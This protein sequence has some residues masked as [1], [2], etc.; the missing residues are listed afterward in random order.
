M[1]VR[2]EHL[3]TVT[4][5]ALGARRFEDATPEE[6]R[7]ND[8]SCAICQQDMQTA[9]KLPCGHMFHRMCARQW[10]QRM[11]S[12]GTCPI[13]R[14]SVLAS[15]S[16]TQPAHPAPAPADPNAA[17]AA[18]STVASVAAVPV[19]AVEAPHAADAA[20]PGAPGAAPAGQPLPPRVP[21]DVRRPGE[22]VER[23]TRL[24]RPTADFGAER[25]IF[26]FSSSGIGSWVP[27]PDFTF[28]VTR[29]AIGSGGTRGGT[30]TAALDGSG[31]PRPPLP[32]PSFS[33][34]MDPVALDGM[35]QTVLAVLPQLSPQA[36]RADLAVTGS[37]EATIERGL[38]GLIAIAELP[39]SP[40]PHN[41]SVAAGAGG[42][43]VAP[44]LA[45][46]E[47]DASIEAELAAIDPK[48][49]NQRFALFQAR[50]RSM[51]RKA[52]RDYLRKTGGQ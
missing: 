48:D 41:R 32:F 25:P 28:E 6:L 50:K 17:V 8:D 23:L 36:V 13:C 19:A 20:L 49:P 46:E 47:D 38:A 7:A 43:P 31:V 33:R 9:K 40:P 29:G 34:A 37:A 45:P 15:P 5:C 39:V 26:R 1:R 12:D 11:N 2:P 35:V 52:R 42:E 14:R 18:A 3:M 30:P 44:F 16:P 4:V 22:P 21:G 24:T 27:F 51:L 10:L